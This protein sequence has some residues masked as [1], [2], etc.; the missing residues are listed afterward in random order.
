[1]GMRTYISSYFTSE[2]VSSREPPWRWS[3]TENVPADWLQI[4]LANKNTG[5]VGRQKK[6][7]IS[8]RLSFL[9]N[10]FPFFPSI[11][12]NGE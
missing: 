8:R 4:N 10:I 2:K 9:R 11:K 5:Q 12:R 1:M 7:T 6:L 3:K